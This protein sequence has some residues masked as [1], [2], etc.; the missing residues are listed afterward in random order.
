MRYLQAAA[1]RFTTDHDAIARPTSA[2]DGDYASVG[3]APDQREATFERSPLLIDGL[4]TG[5]TVL[6]SSCAYALLICDV[7]LR[8]GVSDKEPTLP[9]VKLVIAMTFR[10]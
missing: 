4:H 9:A 2:E 8:Y 1:V 5:T 3:D 7:R 6:C 10:P